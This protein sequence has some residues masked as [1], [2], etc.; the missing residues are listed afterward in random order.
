MNQ[1]IAMILLRYVSFSSADVE[2]DPWFDGILPFSRFDPLCGVRTAPAT[3]QR[4]FQ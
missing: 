1:W 3:Q 4:N 2:D